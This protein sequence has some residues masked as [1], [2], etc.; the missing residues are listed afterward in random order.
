MT[1]LPEQVQCKTFNKLEEQE[2]LLRIALKGGDLGYFDYYPQSGQLYWSDR[3]KEMFGL[4]PE[5]EI[6]YSIYLK[7]LHPDG[8]QGCD[9]AVQRAITHPGGGYNHEYRAIGFADGKLRWVRSKGKIFL[10]EAGNAFHFTG[11]TRDITQQKSSEEK[12]KASE[13]RYRDIF[14]GLHRVKKLPCAIMDGS[15][16]KEKK[17]WAPLFMCCYLWNKKLA[18]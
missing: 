3:T 11:V 7:G 18:L 13:A 16:R 4:P 14:E 6:D 10:D 15:R 1:E 5:A 9:E 12:I 17:E 8:R 2:E